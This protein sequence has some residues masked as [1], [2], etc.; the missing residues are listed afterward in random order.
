LFPATHSTTVTITL[1]NAVFENEMYPFLKNMMVAINRSLTVTGKL[2]RFNMQY[3][4]VA[5]WALD[6]PRASRF[7]VHDVNPCVLAMVK[8]VLRPWGEYDF[9]PFSQ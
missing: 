8:D 5:V 7:I 6:S 1:G 4:A 9:G 3:G 2:P